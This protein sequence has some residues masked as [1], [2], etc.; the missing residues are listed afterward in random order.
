MAQGV[1]QVHRETVRMRVRE[2][3]ITAACGERKS[4][5]KDTNINKISITQQ[6]I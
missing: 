5:Q 1:G 2:W 4:A 3:G 6:L